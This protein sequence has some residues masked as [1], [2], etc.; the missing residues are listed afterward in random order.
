MG[1]LREVKTAKP[2]VDSKNYTISGTSGVSG[3][4]VAYDKEWPADKVV[5]DALNKVTW[6]F[7]CVQAIS[8]NAA[9]VPLVMRRGN[10][11]DGEPILSHELIY[12]LNSRANVGETSYSFRYR[13][14]AQVLLSS[15]G[16]FIEVTRSARGKVTA[17]T[18]LP[19]EDM[20]VIRDPKT[21]VKAYE[22]N[23]TVMGSDGFPKPFKHTY[24]P[25]EVIWIRNPHLF[26]PYGSMTPLSSL[27][28]AIETDWYAK[29]YNRN[30][31]LNDGRPGGIVVLKG[32]TTPEDREDIQSRYRGGV[33]T[34][35]RISVLSGGAGADFVD[36][37]TNPRDAQYVDTRKI[38]KDEIL[39][40][41][42]VPESVLSNAAGRTF[43]N[44]EMERLI[45]WEETMLPHLDLIT[46]ELEV[47]DPNVK[48][49]IGVDTDRVD[50]LQRMEIKR[51]EYVLREYAE[52]LIDKNEYRLE[53]GRKAIPGDYGKVMFRKNVDIPFMMSDGSDLPKVQGVV[54]APL[55]TP[56][57]QIA[58]NPNAT[59]AQPGKPAISKPKPDRTNDPGTN[60]PGTRNDDRPKPAPS[61]AR[62]KK[63]VSIPE[64]EFKAVEEVGLDVES[65]RGQTYNDFIRW[66]AVVDNTVK[67]L[68]DR[69]QRVVTEKLKSEK[70]RK[71]FGRR[72][73][74]LENG[75]V[76]G[77][78][79]NGDINLKS[80][81]DNIY[82]RNVWDKQLAEDLRPILSGIFKEFGEAVAVEF[83]ETDLGIQNVIEAQIDSV[84][85]VNRD[86]REK[87]AAVVAA[88]A[89]ADQDADQ[90]ATNLEKLFDETRQIEV[91][92]LAKRYVTSAANAASYIAGVGAG[93]TTKTW[94]PLEL[95]TGDDMITLP[96]REEFA[97]DDGTKVLYPGESYKDNVARVAMLVS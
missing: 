93:K 10:P 85:Q 54:N 70:M 7:R 17:L 44:A 82:H 52:N 18:L 43:D 26:D 71:L 14:S 50:V 2:E 1:W 94:V 56:P 53:T 51:K 59:V 47:L 28:L 41:F 36:T 78:S 6:V 24:Q 22:L 90:I 29:M 97:Y 40:G 11:Y 15:K 68:I 88:G 45:F 89:M 8:S 74:A 57:K 73:A 19:P 37:A 3:P 65:F 49:Y 66:E 92:A 91:P 13:L 67:R 20:K 4:Y 21:F 32:E 25:D 63:D 84:L 79:A 80:A 75:P 31:L 16:A 9:R 38:T 23:T 12:P 64:L 81:I 30:F 61:V 95:E 48:T 27:G 5:S 76:T 86:T 35:G 77:L 39:I 46:R 72:S 60:E 83:D 62:P 69:Q 87:V 58:V 42:G 33:S 96:I 34:A 55:P